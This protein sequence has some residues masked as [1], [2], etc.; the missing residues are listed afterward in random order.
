MINANRLA[1]KTVLIT[2]A[3]SG[4]GKS[5]AQL[6]ASYG[7]KI[8]LVAR[9]IE[10]LNI[11]KEQLQQQHQVQVYCH[12]LDVTDLAG[13]KD[14]FATLPDA[15]KSIDVLVNNAGLSLGLDHFV[16][17]K[18]GDWNT[19]IDT[20]LKGLLYV[21]Q[22]TLNI[23]YKQNSGHIINIGSIA[24]IMPYANGTVYCATKAAVQA[25]S[26]ALRQEC[27][28][29][30]IKV[31]LIAPGLLNTEFSAVRFYGDQEK[32]DSVYANIDPLLP[33]DI[34]DLIVYCANAPSHV[35]LAEVMIMPT[36]QAGPTMVKRKTAK[37]QP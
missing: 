4:I 15:F 18:A 11:L 12:Q 1:N 2:G 34:A 29:K 25:F 37:A 28:E 32:A 14:F 21:A 16:N 23:M 24:G 20:N 3:S 8:I 10:R 22:Q 27:I 17:S 13:V 30:N 26:T 31:T 5:C 7:A 35:N 36:C 33:Q 6:F 19:M 9:R